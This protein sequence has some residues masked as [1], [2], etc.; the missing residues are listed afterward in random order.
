MRKHPTNFAGKLFCFKRLLSVEQRN[1]SEVTG[2]KPKHTNK[3]DDWCIKH[4]HLSN[5]IP[6]LT[7]WEPQTCEL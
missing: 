5:T 2:K 1:L 6:H 4:S 3:E 7:V